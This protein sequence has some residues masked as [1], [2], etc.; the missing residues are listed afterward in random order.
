[1]RSGRID[2]DTKCL[3]KCVLCRQLLAKVLE[4]SSGSLPAFVRTVVMLSDVQTEDIFANITRR[5]KKKFCLL[6]PPEA[7]KVGPLF[8]VYVQV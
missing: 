8:T 5:R 3:T 7:P 6:L 2:K 4:N 1:M